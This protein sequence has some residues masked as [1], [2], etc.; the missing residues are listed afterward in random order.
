M[1]ENTIGKIILEAG[2]R[3]AAQSGGG[4]VPG[5]GLVGGESS[6]SA[7]R[8]V[9]KETRAWQGKMLSGMADQPRWWTRMFKTMGISVGLSGI[10]KQSQIFTGIDGA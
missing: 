1:P 3:A 4:T 5:Q 9:Q 7:G 2:S 6:E 8:K 10:L